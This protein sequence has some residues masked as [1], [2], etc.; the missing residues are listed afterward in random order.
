L[1]RAAPSIAENETRLG[2]ESQR[3]IAAINT[4]ALPP[5]CIGSRLV[6]L[7]R[8]DADRGEEFRRP[9]SPPP[10]AVTFTREFALNARVAMGFD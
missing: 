7:S 4:A 9:R 10:M 8:G 3:R 1:W 6:L 5:D 2:A